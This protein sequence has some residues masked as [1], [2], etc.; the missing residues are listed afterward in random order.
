MSI[1]FSEKLTFWSG[2]WIRRPTLAER[3]SGICGRFRMRVKLS[4]GDELL[5]INPPMETPTRRE[6]VAQRPERDVT[7]E[8][9][10]KTGFP[11]L[12]GK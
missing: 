8:N 10:R 9:V 4:A 2:D 3:S 6:K 12:L 1:V 11:S 7:K 5:A